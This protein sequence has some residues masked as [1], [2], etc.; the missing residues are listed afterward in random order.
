MPGTEVYAI[1]SNRAVLEGDPTSRNQDDLTALWRVED[2]ELVGWALFC[3]PGTAT[4]KY[5][6]HPKS[7][8]LPCTSYTEE[9]I[10]VEVN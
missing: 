6:D 2:A 3:F 5:V 7:T 9:M 10:N 4:R 1:C 8:S